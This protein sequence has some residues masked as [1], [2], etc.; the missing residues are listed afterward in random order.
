M[1]KALVTVSTTV[2]QKYADVDRLRYNSRT[3]NLPGADFNGLTII[4]KKGRPLGKASVAGPNE[5]SARPMS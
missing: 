4:E 2:R 1:L 3:N 5:E